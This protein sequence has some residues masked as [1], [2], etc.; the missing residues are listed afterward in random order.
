VYI[1]AN[2]DGEGGA[3][4]VLVYTNASG[5]Y[6][7]TG[8]KP[9]TYTLI[10]EANNGYFT[11]APAMGVVVVTLA[12][13]QGVGGIN[14]A[15]S[16]HIHGGFGTVVGI[17][18]NDPDG[19][20]MRGAGETGIGGRT[21]FV[22]VNLNGVHNAGEPI[23]VTDAEGRY[24]LTGVPSAKSRLIGVVPAG[25]TATNNA[26]QEINLLPGYTLTRNFATRQAANLVAA[27]AGS[28]SSA[29][30]APVDS[31]GPSLLSSDGGDILE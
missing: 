19:N 23:A 21:V 27:P 1:D 5:E 26:V 10:H 13:G 17:A 9:G 20:G 30:A 24:T 25:W 22:D 3:G 29:A 11:V 7:F 6:A 8:L 28:A 12:S 15:D 14:F 16:N 18:F 31:E 4:D 2:Q